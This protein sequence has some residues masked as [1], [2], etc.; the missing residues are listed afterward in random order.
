MTKQEE[1]ASPSEN[2]LPNSDTHQT[3][4]TMVGLL[5]NLWTHW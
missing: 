4:I 3:I 1:P 2:P 5:A